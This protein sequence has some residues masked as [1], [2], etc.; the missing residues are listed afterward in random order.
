M[1]KNKDIK[2]DTDKFLKEESK[3]VNNKSYMYLLTIQDIH[4]KLK[5]WRKERNI[6]VKDQQ[7]SYLANIYEEASEYYRAIDLEHKVD[8]LCDIAVFTFNCIDRFYINLLNN[9]IKYQDTKKIYTSDIIE[10]INKMY[11][12][13]PMIDECNYYS[14]ISTIFYHLEHLAYI[15]PIQALNE[16]IEEISSRT[17][18]P[19][20]KEIWDRLNK[21]ETIEELKENYKDY[22]NLLTM[23]FVKDTSSKAM[24]RWYKA[25]YLK[26]K[27]TKE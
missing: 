15:D 11:K 20:Q 24:R 16:T 4:T 14:V 25:D 7:D 17:Q 19:I 2:T 26:C 18:H 10:I 9:A 12:Y 1:I 6:A 22:S 13:Y 5:K 21:G 3:I 23:K 8:A 27:I